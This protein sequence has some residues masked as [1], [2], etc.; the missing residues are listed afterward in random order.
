M[1]RGTCNDCTTDPY[2]PNNR[3]NLHRFALPLRLH[4]PTYLFDLRVGSAVKHEP[5]GRGAEAG[6]GGRHRAVSVVFGAIDLH[7]EDII[8]ESAVMF[9]NLSRGSRRP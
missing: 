1:I 4:S 8:F 3:S 7:A 6:A 2:Q 5:R 9:K